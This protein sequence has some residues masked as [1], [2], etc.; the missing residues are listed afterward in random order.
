M[1]VYYFL[2]K[3][4]GILFIMVIILY[5]YNVIFF[6]FG[7]GDFYGGFNCFRFR[8]LEEEVV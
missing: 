8:I 3:V 5:Y 6:C 1:L 4:F 2:V 7:F